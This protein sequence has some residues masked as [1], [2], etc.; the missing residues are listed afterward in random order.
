[1]TT[2]TF[3]PPPDSPKIVTLPASPPKAAIL[4]RTHSSAATMSSIP[5]FPDAA[6]SQPLIDRPDYDVAFAAQIGSVVPRRIA[7][8]RDERAAMA[9]E[10]HRA[11]APVV[12]R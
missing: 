9:P 10:H 3:A 1:M 6:T 11:F 4:S 12:H 8:S 5:A 7:R 2:V